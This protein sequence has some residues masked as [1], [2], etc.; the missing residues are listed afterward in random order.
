M[1]YKP[2]ALVILENILCFPQSLLACI[3]LLS[4]SA[5][6]F[7]ISTLDAVAG[8]GCPAYRTMFCGHVCEDDSKLLKAAA[9]VWHGKV[10]KVTQLGRT[11]HVAPDTLR[12]TV[13]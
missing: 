7:I 6:S 2:E 5:T 4:L 8:C 12:N 11:H 10:G 3:V 13:S 1:N 9:A